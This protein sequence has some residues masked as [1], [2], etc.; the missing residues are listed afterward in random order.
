MSLVLAAPPS[1][2]PA[3]SANTNTMR[4]T[5][6]FSNLPNDII[7]EIL[8]ILSGIGRKNIFIATIQN[9]Y[10]EYVISATHICQS[11]RKA[12]LE[13]PILWNHIVI[14]L[15]CQDQVM[16]YI[17]RS[18]SMPLI[19]YV[20]DKA[21]TLD[22]LESVLYRICD[23]H[24]YLD[25]TLVEGLNLAHYLSKC[26]DL[27]TLRIV[28]NTYA[29][30]RDQHAF[31][32]NLLQTPIP[33]LQRLSVQ[34]FSFTSDL[35]WL[36]NLTHLSL[37]SVYMPLEEFLNV[38]S[39]CSK[40]EYLRLG[41]SGS[42]PASPPSPM[43]PHIR[44]A[45][46]L[47]RDFIL[48]TDIFHEHFDI[49]IF[50]HLNLPSLINASIVWNHP[51]LRLFR[52]G[53]AL[54]FNDIPRVERCDLL[55]ISAGPQHL[56]VEGI[57]LQNSNAFGTKR[58]KM[59]WRFPVFSSDRCGYS[60]FVEHIFKD[61]TV[62]SDGIFPGVK[63]LKFSFSGLQTTVPKS[64]ES[65]ELLNSMSQVERLIFFARADG[66]T[67][68][69]KDLHMNIIEAIGASDI[70]SVVESL[71]SSRLH[72]IQI[73]GFRFQVET[74]S[75]DCPIFDLLMKVLLRRKNLDYPL[76]Q[77]HINKANGLTMEHVC[78]LRTVVDSV[79]WD[80]E[81]NIIPTKREIVTE[82][83]SIA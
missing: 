16:Q 11:W 74:Q 30:G 76:R 47:L 31:P 20:S 62:I 37:R 53:N 67:E 78:Q 45:L 48:E 13:Y 41:H 69:Y 21:R 8:R 19:I 38:M 35:I 2:G 15:F 36:G 22:A 26:G 4:A 46:P 61:L 52:A 28:L 68:T 80:K 10:R 58:V 75:L 40:L 14:P 29:Q 66:L 18:E 73:I 65:K 24:L 64:D 82:Q 55:E 83:V 44:V 7:C 1:P 6:S 72:C 39:S 59:T 49:D 9:V 60:Y 3:D 43:E 71:R 25:P 63:T 34:D 17:S 12:A 23:W 54:F 42:C 79:I 51:G 57:S 50:H 56:V 33:K 5:G 81:F 70:F 32:M 27:N 77:L